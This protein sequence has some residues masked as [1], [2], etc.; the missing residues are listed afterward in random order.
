MAPCPQVED[1]GVLITG[2]GHDAAALAL[3]APSQVCGYDDALDC[4]D[5]GE[6]DPGNKAPDA[7]P[8]PGGGQRG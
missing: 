7:V 2:N 5:N 3:S 8:S 1:I 6:S 4:S